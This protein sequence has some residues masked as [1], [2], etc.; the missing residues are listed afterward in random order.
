MACFLKEIINENRYAYKSDVNLEPLK[1]K[2]PYWICPS[3]LSANFAH[4]G[5][6]VRKALEAGADRIHVDVMDNHYVPNL[7]FGPLVVE[8]LRKD[9]ITAPMDVHLMVEPVDDLIK[10]FA[11]GATLIYFHPETSKHIDRSLQLIKSLGCEAALVFNPGTPLS[12]L[13]YVWDKLDRIMLM[14]VNPGFGGQAFIPE[15]LNKAREVS[16]LIQAHKPEVRL[17]MDG[18]VKPQNIREIAEA[19]VDTFVAGSAIFGADNYKT[20]ITEMRENLK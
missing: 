15:M 7:T 12:Y 17:E 19:G 11:A 5:D 8:A 3:I 6:D 1:M 4:L 2:N 9:S 10:S 20:V 13:D 16:K 14:S 18:G